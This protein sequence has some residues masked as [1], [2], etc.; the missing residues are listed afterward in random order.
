MPYVLVNNRIINY[1]KASELRK[2]LIQK[3]ATKLYSSLVLVEWSKTIVNLAGVINH[4][5]TLHTL[6]PDGCTAD[7][8]TRFEEELKAKNNHFAQMSSLPSIICLLDNQML[9]A[10]TKGKFFVND[11]IVKVKLQYLKKNFCSNFYRLLNAKGGSAKVLDL[12]DSLVSN[13][14]RILSTSKRNMHAAYLV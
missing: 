12:A 9:Y 3:A 2:N 13:L 4:L 7:E 10:G 1:Q 5:K 8:L 14:R 6:Y 11:E